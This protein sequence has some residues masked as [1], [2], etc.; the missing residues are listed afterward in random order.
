MI[1]NIDC[2]DF[3]VEE[4]FAAVLPLRFRKRVSYEIPSVEDYPVVD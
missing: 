1:A 3:R 4:E 2:V